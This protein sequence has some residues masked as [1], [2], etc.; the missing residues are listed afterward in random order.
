MG[1]AEKSV[2]K[3]SLR[4]QRLALAGTVGVDA[5][6]SGFPRITRERMGRSSQNLVYLTIEQFYTFPEN[7]KSVPT[8]T[9]DLISGVMSSENCVAYRFNA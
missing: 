2:L 5:P 3:L 7:L 4:G 9:F 1:E 6:P 8:M